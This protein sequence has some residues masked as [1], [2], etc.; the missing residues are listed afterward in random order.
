ML[1]RQVARLKLFLNAGDF[2]Y[3]KVLKDKILFPRYLFAGCC[4]ARQ[5]GGELHSPPLDPPIALIIQGSSKILLSDSRVKRILTLKIFNS[6]IYSVLF[7]T[8]CQ[9]ND[10]KLE[11]WC[12][13]SG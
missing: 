6:L 8:E 5:G 7:G 13:M 3:Y 10:K 4:A 12:G 2:I 1:F 9:M 11:S